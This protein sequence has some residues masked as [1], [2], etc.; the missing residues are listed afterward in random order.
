M[1]DDMFSD[2]GKKTVELNEDRDQPLPYN[3]LNTYLAEVARHPLLTAEKEREITLLVFEKND[4]GAA[5]ELVMSN[6]RL[7]VKIALQY[8]N[9]YLNVLDLIQEGNVGMLHAVKRYNPYKGTKFSATPHTGS[10]PTY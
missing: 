1:I 4:S 5:Q 10:E 2:N 8:Y 6:L 9:T 3:S 7:V